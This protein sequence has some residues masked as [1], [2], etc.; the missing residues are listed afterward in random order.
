MIQE[1]IPK[2]KDKIILVVD[3]YPYN[4]TSVETIL[5]DQGFK[6]ILVASSGTDALSIIN[7]KKP[8]LI[9]LDIMMPDLDGFEICSIL[10]SNKE[11]SDIPVIMITARIS[12]K[13]LKRGFEVGAVDYIEKPFDK[14][15]LIAR[16]QSALK[17]KQ[18]RDD[19]ISDRDRQIEE[20][21]REGRK[22]LDELLK[23]HTMELG[24]INEQ[25]QREISERKRV[26]DALTESEENWHL[27]VQN[28]PDIVI[29]VDKD[30]TILSIN[31]TLPGISVEGATG[32]NVYDYVP[33]EHHES[34]KKSFERTFKTGKSGT[35]EVLGTGPNGPATSFYETRI[36][37]LK[38][39]NKVIA[40]TLISTE[41]TERKRAEKLIHI[42]RD[43]ALSLSAISELEEGLRLCVEA[44]L[45]A[46]EM[47]SGGV[48][49]VDEASGGALD[50]MFYMGLSY[51]FVDSV[52]HYD[53]DSKNAEVVLAGKPIYTKYEKLGVPLGEAE[54]R[55]GLLAIAV[56]P[57][58]HE[59]RVIGCMNIAAHTLEEVPLFAR[60]A[61]EVIAA[62]IG[63]AI[64]R[65]RSEK[66]LQ[67]SEERYHTI[68]EG[69]ID[70]I[71]VLRGTK[72][73]YINQNVSYISGYS[74]EELYGLDFNK[75]VSP[76]HLQ[77][78][79]DVYLRRTV[80]KEVPSA[81]EIV[82][83][84]K[85]GHSIWLEISGTWIEY[86]DGKAFMIF[87]HDIT[88]RKQAEEAIKIEQ[89]KYRNVVESIGEGLFVTDKDGVV[90]Y[91]NPEAER[92]TGYKTAEVIG[93]QIKEL[94]SKDVI[95]TID[96][97]LQK[98]IKGEPSQSFEAE[99][100]RKDN[101]LVFVEVT[102]IAN[103][104]DGD[105]IE[106]MGVIRDITDRKH[107]EEKLKEA[108][109][110]LEGLRKEL[111]Q[112]AYVASHDLKEPLRMVSGFI[113]LISNQYKGKLDS[114]ADEFIDFAIDGS[115][116]MRNMVG[117]LLE[118]SRVSTRG[119]PFKST[120]SNMV[121]G[122]ALYNLSST[123][124]TS[125]AVITHDP[126]P[127]VMA[128]SM[129]LVQLFQKLIDNAIM[130][131]GEKEAHIH[132][133]AEKKDNGLVFSVEDNGI[134]I[135]PEYKD[136]VFQIFRRL[137]E[138]DG[139]GTGMGLAICKKIVE[140]HGGKIWVESDIGNG[141]K[142]C[143]TIPVGGMKKNGQFRYNGCV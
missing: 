52:S 21:L 121:L 91:L 1:E 127:T 20:K 59:N 134:G 136:Q 30:G 138:K 44:A 132:I 7:E 29:T 28:V 109:E 45:A 97:P 108:L 103:K 42:Q 129:Q 13:D 61:M 105:I 41:I 6:N 79:L 106:F 83:I 100:R 86:Q 139:S 35:Y 4:L 111:D 25:L 72:V 76:E 26:E 14:L 124:Q 71:V 135:N 63:S 112:F 33:S 118:Y 16:V 125:G 113:Q 32:S 75:F 31:R 88:E 81:C 19:I 130:Y 92:L 107:S 54:Q 70:G 99:F 34:L 2:E 85:D 24:K 120:N 22:Y 62:Q 143:F 57:I 141:S 137:H 37:P 56:I 65:M 12:S 18:S 133:S 140:R 36:V 40:A 47:D 50:L 48:Y 77:K 53:S 60:D 23:K 131:R 115:N 78:T 104:K 114:D 84:H 68:V 74:L 9:L 122:L 8:D 15:E 101:T 3:D 93:K 39:D 98:V 46:S 67:E 51:D 49:L 38:R 66:T 116:R 128:D 87:L 94:V 5:S 82:A 142:F 69:C 11:T 117:S 43:L 102:L 17:L 73:A 126:M 90:T 96:F 95:K 89:E 119:K 64:S 80:G 55:E 10:Q 123:I 27:L 58:Y 110:D